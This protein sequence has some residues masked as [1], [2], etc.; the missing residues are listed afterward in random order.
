MSTVNSRLLLIS[1]LVVIGV[2][3]L[4]LVVGIV[5]YGSPG[6]LFEVF[7]VGIE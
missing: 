7:K 2:M 5:F 3:I 6:K 1:G 4:L